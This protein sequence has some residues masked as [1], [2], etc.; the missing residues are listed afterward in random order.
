MNPGVALARR[1]LSLPPRRFAV[2]H[3]T[4]WVA[5]SDGVRLATSVLL[6]RERRGAMAGGAD[7]NRGA[8]ARARRRGGAARP[9]RGGDGLRGRAPGVPGPARL[10]GSL[11]AV[12]PR[13]RG[14]RRRDRVDRAPALVRWAPRADRLGLLRLRR[15]GGALAQ[16]AARRRAGGGVSRRAIRTPCCAR[17]ARS[18]SSWRCAGAWGS[19]SASPATR[20]GSTSSAGSFTARCAKPIA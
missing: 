9:A 7:A 12:R 13:G 10:G 19:A 15:L 4:E 17:E 16:R 20:A 8:G 6:P 1:W 5:L 18:R 14:R 2:R 11:R 3:Q